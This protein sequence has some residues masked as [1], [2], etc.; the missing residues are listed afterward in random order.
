MKFSI[1]SQWYTLFPIQAFGFCHQNNCDGTHNLD[2]ILDAD[3]SQLEQKRNRRRRKRK[4]KTRGQS[5]E[6]REDEA[7]ES[8]SAA[9]ESEAVSKMESLSAEEPATKVQ[10]KSENCQ[11]VIASEDSYN[12]VSTD[13]ETENVGASSRQHGSHRAG[14]DAFMTGFALACIINEKG[15]FPSEGEEDD[16][17]RLLRGF[18]MDGEANKLALIGKD[19]PMLITKSSFSKSSQGHR[20]KMERLKASYRR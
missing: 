14:F 1:V 9:L 8:S 20:E 16:V 13:A 15:K 5:V 6:R 18:G 4:A 10:R 19:I 11:S 12:D 2:V 17:G 7:E 3:Q